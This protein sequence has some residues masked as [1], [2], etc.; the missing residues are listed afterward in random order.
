MFITVAPSV[1]AMY[2]LLEMT[3]PSLLNHDPVKISSLLAVTR[4]AIWIELLYSLYISFIPGQSAG[5]QD[6]MCL[7]SILKSVKKNHSL[8]QT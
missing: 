7:S 1:N 6:E 8:S 3:N 5:N 4:E 2:M